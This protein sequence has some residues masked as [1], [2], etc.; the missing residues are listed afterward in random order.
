MGAAHL[1]LGMGQ[2]S[3]AAPRPPGPALHLCLHA[4]AHRLGLG[5]V[6]RR[7]GGDS[8]CPACPPG[9]LWGWAQASPGGGATPEPCRCLQHRSRSSLL[10]RM[11]VC[12]EYTI[13]PKL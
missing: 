6:G 8:E 1:E 12:G 7:A 4:P 9:L 3:P 10:R 13:A 2:E 11:P 5:E